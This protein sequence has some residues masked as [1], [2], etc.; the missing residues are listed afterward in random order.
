MNISGD[1]A[2]RLS[3]TGFSA[4]VNRYK[5]ARAGFFDANNQSSILPLHST[6]FS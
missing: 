3:R 1:I 5:S 4:L 2:D 6:L